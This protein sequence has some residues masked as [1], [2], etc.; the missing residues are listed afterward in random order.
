MRD[1]PSEPSL[2]T[3]P[4]RFYRQVTLLTGA[5]TGVL[6]ATV[7]C[8]ARVWDALGDTGMSAGGHV[9]L[10][11][12]VLVATALRG[13]LMGLVFYRNRRGIDDAVRTSASATDEAGEPDFPTSL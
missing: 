1:Q 7:A 4:T 3:T 6:I 10:A 8:G 2:S 12:G 5:P 9:A 11:V 13:G